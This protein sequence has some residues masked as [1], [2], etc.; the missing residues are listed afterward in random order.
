MD[1]ETAAENPPQQDPALMEGAAMGGD[2]APAD[3]LELGEDGLPI[4]VGEEQKV[5]EIIPEEILIDM[6]NVFSVFDMESTSYVEIKYLRTIMRALDFDLEPA[7]L[8]MV[9]KQID[10]DETGKIKF[11]NFKLVMEDKL[12]DKDTPEDMMAELKH[13]DR[14]RDEK[15]PVPEFK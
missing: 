1:G 14:D 10:P 4:P 3:G 7:E 13:L 2:G 8:E 6:K 15:I 5:D 12:K 11:Q 9:R